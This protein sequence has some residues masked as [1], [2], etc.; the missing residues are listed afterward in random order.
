MITAYGRED[1]IRAAEQAGV[2]GFLIKPVSPSILLDTMFTSWAA[3]PLRGTVRRPRT[4]DLPICGRLAAR[5]LL[6]EDNDINREFATELLRSMNIEVDC[7]VNGEE[8]VAPGAGAQLRRRAD[9][10]PDAGDGW[11]RSGRR[12][13]ALAN[14]PGNERFRVLPIIAMTALAMAQDE[15][16]KQ[17]RR[18][19]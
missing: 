14:T 7:A 12:I 9:G 13:R 19:E 10:H 18:H 4:R 5:L 11:P 15:R 1:V 2:D 3:A 6:V 17:G 8:A 16:E